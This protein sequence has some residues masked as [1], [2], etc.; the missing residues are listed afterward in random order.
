MNSGRPNN[1]GTFG[2]HVF[3]DDEAH[4]MSAKLKQRLGP[5]FI[6][7]RSGPGG[8]KI[9]YLEI[10]KALDLANEIFG[11]NGWSSSVGETV[12][13]YVDPDHGKISLGISCIVRVTLKDGTFHEDIGY[14]SIENARS[15]GMAFEKAKKEAVSDGIKR[16][17]RLFGNSVGNC[18]YDKGFIAKIKKMPNPQV[19]ITLNG[20][21][22]L[23]KL[24]RALELTKTST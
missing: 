12:I 6:S 4:L 13:D 11:Y 24:S 22:T 8:A 3:T 17:L 19:R 7:E 15:K 9:S 21:F 23:K 18:L 5:E 10:G 14:G 16:A 2:T 20:P 1:L